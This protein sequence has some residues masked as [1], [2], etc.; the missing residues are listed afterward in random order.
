[1][2]RKETADPCE[3]QT[4]EQ[5]KA[6]TKRG[7]SKFVYPTHRDETAMSGAHLVTIDPA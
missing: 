6:K 2:V 5:A 4:K 7:G 1:M 3:R